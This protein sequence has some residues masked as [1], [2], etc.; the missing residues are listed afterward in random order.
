L[1]WVGE[2]I[3][4]SLLNGIGYRLKTLWGQVHVKT[5]FLRGEEVNVAPE[6]E[7][8]RR[9]AKSQGIPLKRV[10]EAAFQAYRQG[11]SMTDNL[12]QWLQEV[13]AGRFSVQ[14][15]IFARVGRF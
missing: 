15:A 10:L 11:R 5:G 2:R 7:E 8:C 3:S 13:Q 4:E 14:Q 9:I 6:F 12:V 1:A